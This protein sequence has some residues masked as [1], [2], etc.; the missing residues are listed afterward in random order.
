MEGK[1]LICPK[2]KGG[3]LAFAYNIDNDLVG[4]KCK[5]GVRIQGRIL[6][7]EKDK[8]EI[9]ILKYVEDFIEDRTAHNGVD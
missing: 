1:P 4:L 8:V 5:C 9:E 2:C 6:S 3:M 7:I